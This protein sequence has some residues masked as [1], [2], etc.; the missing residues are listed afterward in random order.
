MPPRQ[1][2]KARASMCPVDHSIDAF[3]LCNSCFISHLEQNPNLK[4]CDLRNFT[5]RGQD[6]TSHGSMLHTLQFIDNI[7]KKVAH[8]R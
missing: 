3:C 6:S 5:C 2:A 1:R 4:A 8:S 7:S